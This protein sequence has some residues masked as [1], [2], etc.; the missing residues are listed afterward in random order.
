MPLGAYRISSYT[1]GGG[2]SQ[3]PSTAVSY[4]LESNTP[5]TQASPF[6]TAPDGSGN[7]YLAWN[8]HGSNGTNSI[9]CTVL[10]I[11]SDGTIT[12]QKTHGNS[13]ITTSGP[14][15]LRVLANGNVAITGTYTTTSSFTLVLDPS[16]GNILYQNTS[17]ITAASGPVAR[18]LGYT[19]GSTAY[20]YA[21]DS[22]QATMAVQSITSSGTL[23][24]RHYSGST[25]TMNQTGGAADSN[26]FAHYS[27]YSAGN[28]STQIFSYDG[29]TFTSVG[30]YG[31]NLSSV[32]RGLTV[33]SSNNIYIVDT[34]RN[35]V[36][37]NSSGTIQWQKLL[38]QGSF[39]SR[40]IS[41][42]GTNV[43]VM[44]TVSNAYY[45]MAF[46][47]ST[48]A[49]TWQN[50]LSAT[51][52]TLNSLAGISH[53]GNQI[54]VLGNNGTDDTV[55]ALNVPKDGTG[56]GTYGIYTYATSTD[57]TVSNQTFT[58]ASSQTFSSNSA[59]ANNNLISTGTPTF[60]MTK[61]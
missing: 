37:L 33:D 54:Y 26:I 14:G 24:A 36:K 23:S 42:D 35:I 55:M 12:W 1:L 56:T 59:T 47:C 27:T 61:Y 58:S 4:L 52:K 46:D 50:K 2:G 11:A 16:N 57:F 38:N 25:V 34:G 51:G 48:G 6:L 3:A 15:G 45:V 39:I 21:Y 40:Q 13:T 32:P 5:G 22:N 49:I 19:S 17:Q 31:Q 29:T 60:T 18:G 43:F 20:G 53:S 8:S 28:S 41:T 44:A 30:A 10:K 9:R 7:F